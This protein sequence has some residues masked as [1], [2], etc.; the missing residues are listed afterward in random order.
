M[1]LNHNLIISAVIACLVAYIGYFYYKTPKDTSALYRIAL[2]EPAAHPAMDEIADGFMTTIN[3]NGSKKYHFTRYNA[4]GNPTLLRAQAEEILHQNYNLIMSIGTDTT[5]TLHE[6]STR[7]NIQTPIVFTAISNPVEV[8]IIAST[9]SSENHIT[10]VQDAPRYKEQL[11]KLLAIKPTTQSLLLVYDPVIKGGAHEKDAK[12]IKKIVNNKNIVFNTTKVFHT[13]EIQAKVQPELQKNDVVM[14]LTDHTTVSGI[15]S[16]VTL[17]N[18]YGVTLYASD[19]N[20]GDKG[21]A[22]AYGVTEYD[23]GSTAAEQALAILEHNKNPQDIPIAVV[24][25]HKIKLN[26]KTMTQQ[27]LILSSDQRDKITLDGG[28]IL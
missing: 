20:S 3:K 1:K 5:Q 24:K 25:N 13:N 19:L 12:E 21:A 26:T 22:L 16:L 28:I 2:F 11:E 15:D 8:G 10:G 4:N 7:K 18:R 17:C 27:G 6:L 14:V 23:Y 9:A